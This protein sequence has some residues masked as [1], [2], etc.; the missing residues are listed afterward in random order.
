MLISILIE[1]RYVPLV[2]T[3][4][5]FWNASGFGVDASLFKVCR[6]APSRWRR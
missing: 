5:R 6:Y 4:S 3:G 1:P 2:R